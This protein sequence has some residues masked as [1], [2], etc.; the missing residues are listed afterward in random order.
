MLL[1]SSPVIAWPRGKPA[2][3]Q[4]FLYIAY[5]TIANPPM[6]KLSNELHVPDQPERSVR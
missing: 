6:C 5:C 4:G 1:A 3:Y 2:I